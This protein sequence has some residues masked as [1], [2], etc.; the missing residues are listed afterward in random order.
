MKKMFNLKKIYFIDI[1]WLF[2]RNILLSVAGLTLL[3]IINQVNIIMSIGIKSTNLHLKISKM[4]LYL[5]P[6]LVSIVLPFS[7]LIGTILLISKFSKENKIIALQN[8]SLGPVELKKPLYLVGII[9]ILINYW[10][11]FSISPGLYKNFKDIQLQISKQ[12]ISDLVEPNTLKS[13]ARGITIYV[14]SK[15]AINNLSGIFISDTRDKNTIKSFVSKSGKITSQGIELINGTYYEMSPSGVG[16]LEFKQYLLTLHSP[17]SVKLSTDPHSMS[18]SELFNA[19]YIEHNPKAAAVLHQKIVW[20][21]YSLLFILIC[22]N[23]E[24]HFSYKS[25][26]RTGSKIWFS[27][28]ICIMISASHF[29]VK[30]LAAKVSD[31]GSMLTYILPIVI[32][33][34]ANRLN[35]IS[36]RN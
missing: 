11:Y 32:Y 26:S 34:C 16:F 25:Y 9:V 15:D 23:L 7:V 1:L 5:A 27:V 29:L 31:G 24:W 30:N 19:S 35:S 13:Y 17:E 4:C 3:G 20:P 21:L 14:Q 12:S 36:N 10:L 22:F 6:Y 18:T 2:S 33:Y 28:V 8:L